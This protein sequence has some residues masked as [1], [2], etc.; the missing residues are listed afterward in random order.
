VDSSARASC[1]IYTT[2]AEID[3]LADTLEQVREFFL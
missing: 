1:G 2:E 3:F